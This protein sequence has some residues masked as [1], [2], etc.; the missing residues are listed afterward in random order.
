M[1]FP[2]ETDDDFEE[3]LEFC[4]EIDFAKI[5]VFPYSKRNGTKA[6]RMGGHVDGITKKERA[7]RLLKLSEWLESKYYEKN[8]GKNEQILVE[9]YKDDYY[10]GHTSN[11]LYLKLKGDFKENEVYNINISKD[12]FTDNSKVVV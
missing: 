7:K 4:K 10:Y 12:M 3:C 2:N 11:Y 5:H 1:G 9:T 8:I 6:A